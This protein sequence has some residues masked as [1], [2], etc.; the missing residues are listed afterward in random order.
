MKLQ[1]FRPACIA[2]LAQKIQYILILGLPQLSRIK[3]GKVLSGARYVSITMRISRSAFSIVV[4][5]DIMRILLTTTRTSGHVDPASAAKTENMLDPFSSLLTVW[6]AIRVSGR[7]SRSI[8]IIY[9]LWKQFRLWESRFATNGIA[10]VW[11]PSPPITS[12]ALI[13]FRRRLRSDCARPSSVL[14]S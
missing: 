8:K 10:P 11:E 13:S 9:Q 1:Q 4:G 5:D 6:H 7:G 3:S 2:K 12:N 14:N